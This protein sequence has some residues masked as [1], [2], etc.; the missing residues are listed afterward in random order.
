MTK[1]SI[2]ALRG[3]TSLPQPN[4]VMDV[5]GYY[6]PGDGGGGKFYWVPAIQDADN[7][8]TIIK[9]DNVADGRW[10]RVI[11]DVINVKW[12]GAKGDASTSDRDALQ[13]AIDFCA[14]RKLYIP[15]G[16]Y[17][18]DAA[19]VISGDYSI[20][21]E[22]EGSNNSMIRITAPDYVIKASGT[23]QKNG[24]FLSGIRLE[25]SGAAGQGGIYLRQFTNG[26]KLSDMVITKVDT[27]IR[28]EDTYY[29]SFENIK[30]HEI[31]SYGI[32]GV[33]IGNEQINAISFSQCYINGAGIHNVYIQGGTSVGQGMNFI[34]C[35]FENSRKTGV[36]IEQQSNV[37][38]SGCYFEGNYVAAQTEALTFNNPMH[39]KIIGY[40]FEVCN[41]KIDSCF[42]SC[43]MNPNVPYVPSTQKCAIYTSDSQLFPGD[44]PVKVTVSNCTFFPRLSPNDVVEYNLYSKGWIWYTGNTNYPVP[45]QNQVLAGR[46]EVVK[47]SNFLDLQYYQSFA[48]PVISP[49]SL[50]GYSD[51]R[52]RVTALRNSPAGYGGGAFRIMEWDHSNPAAEQY[53]PAGNF[54]T[55]QLITDLSINEIRSRKAGSMK[56]T[57]VDLPPATEF[58]VLLEV[59]A[60]DKDNYT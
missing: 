31:N 52:L 10:K 5:L 42:F 16:I 28:L 22:G 20:N 24:I 7:S 58:Y 37:L 18:T 38:F 34:G 30:M 29:G 59:I 14:N 33:K 53:L 1:V 36:V 17:L 19:L 32:H 60:V 21:I 35:T 4:E 50:K 6:N 49:S 8:A 48:L 39:I 13:R 27:G 47:Y 44:R 54:A 45:P 12:F 40:A 2:N 25:G 26:S 55:G 57:Y 9:Q 56:F 23:V 43:A 41:V 11:E 15:T 51:V 3:N 46:N